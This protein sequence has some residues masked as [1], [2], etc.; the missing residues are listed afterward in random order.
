M[1]ARELVMFRA[2]RAAPLQ[3]AEFGRLQAGQQSSEALCRLWMTRARIVPEAGG[4]RIEKRCHRAPPWAE[5]SF[6]F[7][8]R[9]RHQ[10]RDRLSPVRQ[11][12]HWSLI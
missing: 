10:G 2:G 1:G 3:S 7:S 4:V 12:S 11:N 5:R 8:P 9:G 6:G